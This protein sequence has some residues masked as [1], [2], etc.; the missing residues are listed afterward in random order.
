MQHCHLITSKLNV[1]CHMARLIVFTPPEAA[2]AH[3]VGLANR[4]L[5]SRTLHCLHLRKPGAQRAEVRQYLSQLHPA[6]LPLVVLHA[7][8]DLAA[9]FPIKVGCL[10]EEGF[11]AHALEPQY[12]MTV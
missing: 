8:H 3:E 9:E 11:A 12:C 1:R 10:G 5:T 7:H 6:V 4:L 2:S